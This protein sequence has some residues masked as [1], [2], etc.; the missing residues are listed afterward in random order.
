MN[1]SVFDDVLEFH[2]LGCPELIGESPSIPD[3]SVFRLK[4]DLIEEELD[5]IIDAEERGDIAE[6]A[7][8]IVDAIYML[9]GLAISSGIDLEPIWRGV[10]RANMAKVDGSLGPVVRRPDG[11]VLKPEGWSPFVLPDPLPSISEKVGALRRKS[12]KFFHRFRGFFSHAIM[13]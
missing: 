11:K 3:E 12:T 2:V 13:Q 7:D 6:I 9:I 4:I 1:K 8:G 10:H 5:E